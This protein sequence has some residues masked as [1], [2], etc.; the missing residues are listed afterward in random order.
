M[1]LREFSEKALGLWAPCWAGY[2]LS[3]TAPLT[4]CS[5]SLLCGRALLVAHS[6]G[7][8]SKFW[9][10]FLIHKLVGFNER[11]YHFKTEFWDR[12]D[13]WGFPSAC[14]WVLWIICRNKSC[15]KESVPG[16]VTGTAYLLAS[17]GHLM[18]ISCP[19]NEVGKSEPS[20]VSTCYFHWPAGQGSVCSGVLMLVLLTHFQVL[21]LPC[22]LKRVNSGEGGLLF[23]PVT[24]GLI[25]IKQ[26][27]QP[28]F[29]VW[30]CSRRSPSMCC[31]FQWAEMHCSVETP[32]WGLLPISRAIPTYTPVLYV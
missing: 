11:L 20:S 5:L 2:I 29:I 14:W 6:M 21:Q 8:G 3:T 24:S 26:L 18:C 31:V 1:N 25:S 27:L 23:L 9:P 19:Q 28:R 22:N 15:L 13:S 4:I 12:I 16:T 30:K 32:F 17:L 10:G 7:S